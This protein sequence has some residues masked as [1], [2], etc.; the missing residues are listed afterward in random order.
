[1]DKKEQ[2]VELGV[3]YE[4]YVSGNELRGAFGGGV[5]TLKELLSALSGIV[6]HDIPELL[7]ENGNRQIVIVL[8]T[9]IEDLS[10]HPAIPLSAMEDEWAE[11]AKVQ[12]RLTK[13]VEELLK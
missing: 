8:D 6:N 7:G 3:S 10:R 12:K 4:V 11:E 5:Y 13:E 9:E 2:P 1:M